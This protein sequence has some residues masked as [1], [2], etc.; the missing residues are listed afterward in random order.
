[1]PYHE[2]VGSLNYT[3][4]ATHPNI[5]YMVSHLSSFYDCYMPKHWATAVCVLHYL[6]GTKTLAI[7]LG[8]DKTQSLLGYSNSDYANCIDTSHSISS[9]CF[10]LGSSIISWSSRK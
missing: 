4:V 9:Y 1:M 3:A 5:T 8:G 7:I 6:K 2:L 10:S